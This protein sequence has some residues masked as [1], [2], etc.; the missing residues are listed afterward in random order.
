[1]RKKNAEKLKGIRLIELIT[2]KRL[3]SLCVNKGLCFGHKDQTL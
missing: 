3:L 2:P 1:M